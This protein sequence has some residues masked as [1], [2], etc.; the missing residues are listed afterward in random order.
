MG[1]PQP[2]TTDTTQPVAGEP[3]PPP[4]S[5]DTSAT[6][7]PPTSAGTPAAPA[8]AEPAPN[9]DPPPVLADPNAAPEAPDVPASIPAGETASTTPTASA[10]VIV[11]VGALVSHTGCTAG[12]D[13]DE[14]RFGI[15]VALD[16]HNNA[17]VAWLSPATALPADALTEV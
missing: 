5:V 4:S 15:V 8:I 13:N 6:P 7:A 2:P 14:T 10:S 9:Q 1:Y 3:T 11:A 16:E 12:Q 17:F